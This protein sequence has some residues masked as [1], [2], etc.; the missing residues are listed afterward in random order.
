MTTAW[1][2]SRAR[3]TDPLSALADAPRLVR[4]VLRQPFC[5]EY[6]L[7]SR[8]RPSP[9]QVFVDAGACHGDA[10]EAMRLYHPDTPIL[11]FEPDPRRALLLAER[12]AEDAALAVYRCGLSDSEAEAVL[13]APVRSGR[14]LHAE[15]SFDARRVERWDEVRWLETKV[16]PL[17][18]LS[19]DVS[20]LKVAVNGLEA[21]VLAGAS[22]TLQR[23]E[24]LVICAADAAAD[25]FLTGEL[26]WM[27]ARFDGS[28]LIPGEAGPRHGLYAGPA[29]EA[30]LWRAG[31]LA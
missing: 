12:F 29:C 13:A 25:A 26:G 24:P 21:S 18:D 22:E 17:D 6:R 5:G 2:H 3:T 31:L 27:R 19:L 8:L 4:R 16:F 23:C 9:G 20:V 28:R 14:I 11:A 15:A 30:A 1:P 7:L 10:I